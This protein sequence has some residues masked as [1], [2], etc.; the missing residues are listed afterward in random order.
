MA[1]R[2]WWPVSMCALVLTIGD[3]ILGL[4]GAALAGIATAIGARK[5]RPP[6]GDADLA[7]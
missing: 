6:G 5:R 7:A 3:E 1:G 2:R 4:S